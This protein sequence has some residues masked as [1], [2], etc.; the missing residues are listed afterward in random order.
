MPPQRARHQ[1]LALWYKQNKKC[2]THLFSSDNKNGANQTKQFP[3]TLASSSSIRRW[4]RCT[5]ETTCL[6]SLAKDIFLHTWRTQ[7]HTA[8]FVPLKNEHE[9]KCSRKARREKKW[10]KEEESA[11]NDGE[12]PKEKR[13]GKRR[14]SE[15]SKATIKDTHAYANANAHK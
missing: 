12:E 14:H 7:Q 8:Q 2:P 9:R 6:D 10:H 1:Y 5:P 15:K 11:Q 4:K 13:K 3:L